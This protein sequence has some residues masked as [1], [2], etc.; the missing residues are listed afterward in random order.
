ME[1]KPSVIIHRPEQCYF[2]AHVTN[3]GCLQQIKNK[4]H[5]V[6]KLNCYVFL[7]SLK[8][9]I[10]S[11]VKIPF[12]AQMKIE[13]P[14]GSPWWEHSVRN[15]AHLVRH[16]N[17]CDSPAGI[18]KRCRWKTCS[19]WWTIIIKPPLDGASAINATI[20]MES[21]GL[22]LFM[23]QQNTYIHYQTIGTCW[24]ILYCIL[25][26]YCI[27]INIGLARNII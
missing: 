18:S 26:L 23:F 1:A 24:V 11:N 3:S 4:G 8:W 27:V 12:G 5:L 7:F 13:F 2:G 22:T 9:W 14:T 21:N 19:I 16:K 17:L 20:Q 10:I 15:M 25:I 6:S